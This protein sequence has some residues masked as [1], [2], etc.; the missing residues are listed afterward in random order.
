M[1]IAKSVRKAIEE[2]EAGDEE[3]A[4]LHACNAIDGTAQRVFPDWRAGR[5]FKT[6]LRDNYD[7][8]GPMGLPGINILTTRF[9][10]KVRS[11]E[12]PTGGVDLAEIVYGIHRCSHAHG[13]DLPDGFELVN[14][15]R[16]TPR[17]TSIVVTNGYVALSDRIIFALVAVA[18]FNE[19]NQD[20]RVGSDYYL[21]F[22]DSNEMVIDEWWGRKTDALAIFA[23]VAMPSVTLDF[24]D[25]TKGAAN[26]LL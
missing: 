21:D 4:M 11:P 16:N 3:S 1:K 7:I 15:A 12:K 17:R 8:V 13:E 22:D 10:V 18:V 24:N 5:R 9:P 14:D 19:V 20:E 25:W 2:W 23:S 6:L 26:C